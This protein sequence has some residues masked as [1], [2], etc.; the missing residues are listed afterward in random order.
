VSVPEC[1]SGRMAD[2][3]ERVGLAEYQLRAPILWALGGRLVATPGI[4]TVRIRQ[5]GHY[6]CRTG[7]TSLGV[8]VVV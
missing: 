2:T 7:H 3:P 6:E 5:A 8:V 4:T 1:I